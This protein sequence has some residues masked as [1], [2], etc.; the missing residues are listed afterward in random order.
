MPERLGDRH[1]RPR[2]R[3]LEDDAHPLPERSLPATGVEAEHRDLS[4]V[5]SAV[6]LEDLD[7]RRLAGAVRAEQAEDLALLDRERDP[8]N[9]LVVAVR[10]AQA[11]DVDCRRHQT[12]TATTAPGGNAGSGP[13]LSAATVR[14]QS[15]WW[16][17]TTT[18]S[19]RPE[20][21]ALTSSGSAPGASRS[22]ASTS[23]PTAFAI[24]AAVSAHAGAGW[25]AQR[26]AGCPRPRS[27]ARAGG[28]A[29][30]GFGEGTQ[31]VGLAESRLH[32][33]R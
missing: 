14:P 24:S 17:T 31:V 9:G 2:L 4:R 33:A 29:P 19:P 1:L 23:T 26:P 5:A 28:R 30:P 12:S 32:D 11:P 16:P 25:R 20:A 10:L 27:A 6:A 21:A 15:G 22:S 3:V 18:V 13:P 7:G 8:A